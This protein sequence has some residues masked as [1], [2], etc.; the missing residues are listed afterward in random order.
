MNAEFISAIQQ[1]EDEKGISKDILIEAVEMALVKAY[2]KNFVEKNNYNDTLVEKD[3]KK[4]SLEK[5]NVQV[6]IDRETGD[7]KVFSKKEVVNKR[8]IDLLEGEISLEGAQEIDI[9]YKVGD[10]VQEEITPR[11][12]GR[13][14]TQ[15]ARQ[16]VIQKITEAGRDIIYN[17]FSNRESEIMIGEVVRIGKHNTC[18]LNLSLVSE[19]GHTIYGEAT[20]ISQEQIPYEEYSVGQRIIVYILE[21]K[22]H[23]NVPQIL[24][25]RSRPGLV[26][27][28]FEREVPEISDGIV[29]IKS[30]AREAGSRTKLSVCS[31]DPSVDAIGACVGGKGI[32]GGNIFEELKGSEVGA[33]T[34]NLPF[35]I[36]RDKQTNSLF[37]KGLDSFPISLLSSMGMASS[38]SFVDGFS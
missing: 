12:F 11:N 17:E 4:L 22:K 15:T 31:V 36:V 16:V 19:K 7:I 38:S 20:M 29:Q 27:R 34:V 28:L 33:P 10:I 18:H 6:S 1:L 8:E 23:N 5:N 14:A 35:Y 32:R 37:F 24:V 2:K 13:I 21:V 26:K 9:N 25:S 30:I 3:P